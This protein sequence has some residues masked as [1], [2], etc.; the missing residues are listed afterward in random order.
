MRLGVRVRVMVR[1]KPVPP[2][3][4][5]LTQTPNPNP[6]PNPNPAALS[7]SYC[8]HKCGPHLSASSFE[9][10]LRVGEVRLRVRSRVMDK[11]R[12]RG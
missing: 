4:V 8:L 10:G 2:L 6:N 12:V 7:N 11:V 1:V 3:N 9:L 5:G